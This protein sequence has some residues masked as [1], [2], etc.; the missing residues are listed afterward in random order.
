MVAE[1]GE[2][3]LLRI[4]GKLKDFAEEVP[5]KTFKIREGGL[6][7]ESLTINQNILDANR[8]KP[9]LKSKLTLG[10]RGPST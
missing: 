3:P 2:F 6:C 7:S 9:P 8:P 4:I 10:P 1:R 5:T